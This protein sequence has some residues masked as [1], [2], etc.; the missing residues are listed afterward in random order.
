MKKYINMCTMLVTTLCL[1]CATS[2]HG[3]AWLPVHSQYIM[4]TFEPKQLEV[5]PVWTN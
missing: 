1:L 3:S 5:N 2:S 4:N